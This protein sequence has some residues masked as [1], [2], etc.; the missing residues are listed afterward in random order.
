MLKMRSSV[1]TCSKNDGIVP[2]LLV[3]PMQTG[4]YYVR[5]RSHGIRFERDSKLSC[6]R[7]YKENRAIRSHRTP[8]DRGYNGFP[9]SNASSRDGQSSSAT[10]W[11]VDF[12]D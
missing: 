11:I 8:Q 10:R 1:C 6:H 5:T 12:S 3:D 4:T 9:E 7:K 2:T